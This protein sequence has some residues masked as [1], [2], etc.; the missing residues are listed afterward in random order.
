MRWG[1][2]FEDPSRHPEHQVDPTAEVV[3]GR[4]DRHTRPRVDR[5]VGE[6]STPLMAENRE[7]ASRT[8]VLLGSSVPLARLGY[9]PR[10]LTLTA[11]EVLPRGV[12]L[13][14]Y[15]R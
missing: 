2:S 11:S 13:L 9:E 15:R 5:P 1:Q 3:D 10:E 4:A 8:A 12:A 14:T 6:G 7:R